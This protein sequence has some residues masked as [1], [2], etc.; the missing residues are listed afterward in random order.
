MLSTLTVI[1]GQSSRWP[2]IDHFPMSRRGRAICVSVATVSTLAEERRGVIDANTLIHPANKCMW[3][4]VI[5]LHMSILYFSILINNLG[6]FV[7]NEKHRYIVTMTPTA[8]LNVYW[9]T[10]VYSHQ[11]LNFKDQNLVHNE[12]KG[13]LPTFP[14]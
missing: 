11:S 1:Y 13:L 14:Y 8:G 3:E 7:G 2:I 12:N 9:R 10:Y 6:G 5:L 4:A